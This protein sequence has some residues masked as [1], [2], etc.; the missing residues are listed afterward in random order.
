MCRLPTATHVW[1]WKSFLRG[2]N[3]IYMDQIPELGGPVCCGVS[4]FAQ[5]VRQ[6][7]RAT[8][9]YAQKINLA[10]ITSQ[11]GLTSTAYCLA[12]PLTD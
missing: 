7:M 3:P 1:V 11:N 10:A 4:P 6:A 12:H 8:H 9:R 2:L 5:D